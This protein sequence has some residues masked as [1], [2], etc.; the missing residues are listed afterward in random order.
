MLEC[1]SELRLDQPDAVSARD[2]RA[3]RAHSASDSVR[4]AAARPQ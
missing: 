1:G 2:D 3:A 4:D